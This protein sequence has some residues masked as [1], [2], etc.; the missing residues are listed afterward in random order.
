VGV[1]PRAP[2]GYNFLS[3][4]IDTFTK[5]MEAMLVVNITQDVTVKFLQSIIYRFNIP[6]WVLIDNGTQFKGENFA[7][8]CA[9][10]G[11]YHQASSVAHP[12]MNRQVQRANRL[13]L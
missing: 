13:I 1:L 2:G 6:K 5:C 9:N 11:I 3:V 12:Q 4:A 8:C 7:A 10:I